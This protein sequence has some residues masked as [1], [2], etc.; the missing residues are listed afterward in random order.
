MDLICSRCQETKPAE[1]FSKNLRNSRGYQYHCKA[2]NSEVSKLYRSTKREEVN[3]KH[4]A[5]VKKKRLEQYGGGELKD[6]CEI[7]GTTEKLCI[8]HCHASKKFRGTLCTRCNTGLGMFRDS[9]E[10]LRIAATYLETHELK[11]VD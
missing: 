5:R 1:A 2:C 4:Q 3:A 10:F 7:C 6:S 11:L 8:D 9:A